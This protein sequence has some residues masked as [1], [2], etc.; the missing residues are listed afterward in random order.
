MRFSTGVFDPESNMDAYLIGAG[1]TRTFAELE[2]PGDIRHI[3]FTVNGVL[4]WTRTLVLRI[5]WDDSEIP[6]VEAPIGDFFAAGHGMWANVSTTPIEVTSYG[7]S[8]NSYWHMP[9][10]KKARLELVNES[11]ALAGVYCQIDWMQ[12][13]SLPESTLYFHA[14]Y[15]QE[16]PDMPF[17]PYLIFQGQGQGQ[18]VGTVFSGQ[19]C[20]GNWAGESDDRYFIDGEENPS[21]VGTGTEDWFTDAWNMRVF[22]NANAGVTIKE[23]NAVDC[24]YTAYRWHLQA[25]V[26]FRESLRVEYER[27]SLMTV[28]DS[29]TGEKIEHEFEFRPD[30]LSSVAFWYQKGIAKPF[31][32]F[33]PVEERLNPEILVSTRKDTERLPCAPGMQYDN[34]HAQQIYHGLWYMGLRNETIG[35]WLDMPFTLEDEAQYS[36]SA[37]QILFRNCGIWKV[38]LLGPGTEQVLHPA[39]DFYDTTL[40]LKEHYPENFEFG[41]RRE[42][43]LDVVRL[44]PGDYRLRFE[45]IGSNPLSTTDTFGEKGYNLGLNLISVRKL[46]WDHMDKWLKRYMAEKE[47]RYAKM[48]VTAQ[49]TVDK[50]SAAVEAYRRHRGVYPKQLGDLIAKKGPNGQPYYD[51]DRI[52]VDP[53][54]QPYLYVCPG[55]YQPNTFDL[56]SWRGDRFQPSKWI[57]NWNPEDLGIEGA[58]EGESLRVVGGSGGANAH[59]QAIITRFSPPTSR[60]KIL[61]IDFVGRGGS[62]ELALPETIQAGRYRVTLHLFQSWDYAD[63]QW[64]IDETPLGDPVPGHCSEVRPIT[65]KCGVVTLSK[66]PHTL[67]A[68]ALD[69][70]P[71]TKRFC[72]GLDAIVLEPV[73]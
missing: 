26:I 67:R 8:L 31:C 59:P 68:T 45:C 40:T 63:T 62:L 43:K 23:R 38:T 22:T 56:Y 44:T 66:G 1:E 55:Q 10:H 17:E 6:S 28:I 19:S 14:R 65:V 48:D 20:L 70:D 32:A 37:F 71:T 39:L 4:R 41:T 11:E 13:D 33:P 57:K 72:G 36:I 2:G 52:P 29:E 60:G 24:R 46:P 49:E 30:F 7:R 47:R 58:I 42:Q 27:R 34:G 25:P 9:F 15:N 3:W 16:C 21:L 61:F 12:Y 69:A 35:S 64:W 73:N 51:A 53:W 5:Y 18:Y 50:F 54:R